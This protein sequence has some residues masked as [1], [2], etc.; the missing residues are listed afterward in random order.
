MEDHRI[1]ALT[2]PKWGLSMREGQI[3]AWLVQEGAEVGPGVEVVDVETEKVT[4]GLEPMSAGILRRRV[5]G[6]GEMIPV[7]GLIGIIAGSSISDAEID[8]FVAGFRSR[9]AAAGPAGELSGPVPELLHLEGLTLRYLKRGDGGQP[10]VLLH[11]FGGDLN[12]WL[13][14]HEALASGRAVYALDLPGHGG[15]SKLSGQHDIP[16]LAGALAAFLDATGI[17]RT[18]LVGHSLGGAVALQFAAAHPERTASLVLVASAGLGEEID[19]GYVEGFISAS[20]RK[21][22]QP[23]LDRLFTDPALV[24]KRLVD[25]VL[26]YKRI[27][28][29]GASLR[30]IADH[31]WPAGKQAQ[32]LRGVLEQLPLPRLVIW[33]SE[34]RIIPAAH[35]QGLAAGVAAHILPGSGHMVHM[36]A[37][38]E[39]NRLIENFWKA[40]GAATASLSSS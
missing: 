34:D 24:S 38:G 7:G 25:D 11:G 6:L 1:H 14:N 28:G 17:G 16:E 30:L 12:S 39:V 3:A 21:E 31:F 29:V 19:G 9:S 37:A 2:M 40:A 32:V 8:D 4:G 27:D 26:K 23:L 15:S 13:F 22:I 10:A 5:A 33:G 36:E 18:H 35:A 20:R